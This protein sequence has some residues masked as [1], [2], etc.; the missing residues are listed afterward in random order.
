MGER[1]DTNTDPAKDCTRTE[2]N[3]KERKKI[4]KQRDKGVY[5]SV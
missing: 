3:N 4:G 2:L 1:K 5:K